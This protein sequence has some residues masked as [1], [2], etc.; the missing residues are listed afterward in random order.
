MMAVFMKKFLQWFF[1]EYFAGL[2]AFILILALYSVF[3]LRDFSDNIYRA[4]GM[5]FAIMFFKIISGYY[6]FLFFAYKKFDFYNKVSFIFS[7]LL[8]FLLAFV[9]V[10]LLVLIYDFDMNSFFVH[11]KRTF[12]NFFYW[13]KP[14]SI[15]VYSGILAAIIS[16]LILVGIRRLVRMFGKKLPASR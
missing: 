11:F 7:A 15:F 16:P 14:L 3:N 4:G 12:L 10:I 6:L 13:R 5:P 8:L 2:I 9:A 1:A